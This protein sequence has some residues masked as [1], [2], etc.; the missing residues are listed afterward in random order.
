ML[1]DGTLGDRVTASYDF[2]AYRES[3]VTLKAQ[4]YSRNYI[5]RYNARSV[6][7]G[8]AGSMEDQR[9]PFNQKILLSPCTLTREG[10]T[11]AGWSTSSSIYGEVDYADGAEFLREW[12]YGDYDYWGD[13]EE[14][15]VDGESF[16]LY[17]CWTKIM[18][19]E[20]AAAREKLEAAKTLL[21]KTYQ[22]S[23]KTDK[24]L[25]TMAQARLTAGKIEGVTVA[26]KAAVS[27][28]DLFTAARAGIDLD[29]TLHYKWNDNGST[30]ST[31]PICR[32][33]QAR[34]SKSP[35]RP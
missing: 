33:L 15:S 16:D 27:T 2:S 35:S 18:S 20:E 3:G 13:Y 32:S 14:G 8:V 29:G 23:F 22:P 12:D 10:Y 30:N 25:L 24:N 4:W 5:I 31:M 6:D 21:E 19:E 7:S 26:M 1:A 11:F 17:A 28:K 34:Q 9:A